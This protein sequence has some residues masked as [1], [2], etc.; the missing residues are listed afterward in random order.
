MH[1]I[2]REKAKAEALLRSDP[3]ARPQ[4][5]QPED[6]RLL[7]DPLIF[8]RK[9]IGEVGTPGV[10]YDKYHDICFCYLEGVDR[11]ERCK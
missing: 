10:L 6:V 1:L 11:N 5:Q 8:I 7:A 2:H 3:K 4:T 9:W